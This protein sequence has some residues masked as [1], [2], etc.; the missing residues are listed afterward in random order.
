MRVAASGGCVVGAGFF[1]GEAGQVV[2][3]SGFGTGAGQA[4]SAE[5][6]DSYYCAY[7]VAIDVGVA[8]AGAVEYILGEAVNAAVYAQG[9]AVAG[10]VYF[11]YYGG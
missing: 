11:I 2:G 10:C 5:W 6:V 3:A 7:H 9:E 1:G 4:L 8:Y